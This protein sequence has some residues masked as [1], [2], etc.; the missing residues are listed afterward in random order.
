M[1][2]CYQTDDNEGGD[3]IT[4][5]DRKQ[6]SGH[7]ICKNIYQELYGLFLHQKW[8]GIQR[9]EAAEEENIFDEIFYWQ[10]LPSQQLSRVIKEGNEREPFSRKTT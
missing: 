5:F 4:Y 9:Q 6:T 2:L 1:L 8:V 3:K 7:F 10:S